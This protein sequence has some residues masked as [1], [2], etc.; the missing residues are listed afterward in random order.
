MRERS[1]MGYKY[2]EK[3]VY[4]TCY[5]MILQSEGVGERVRGEMMFCLSDLKKNKNSTSEQPC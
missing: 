3:D 2:Q 1:E 4:T 5:L